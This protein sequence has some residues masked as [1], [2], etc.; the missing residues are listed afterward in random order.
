M[1]TTSDIGLHLESSLP[2]ESKWLTGKEKGRLG[3]LFAN[4]CPQMSAEVVDAKTT[5]D[6][7]KFTQ[8]KLDHFFFS[9]NN[10]L[11]DLLHNSSVRYVAL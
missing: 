4:S 8:R 5:A 1:R 3:A 9:F 10:L 7:G 11:D 6:L 2:N